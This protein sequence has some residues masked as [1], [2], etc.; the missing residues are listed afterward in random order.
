MYVIHINIES[1]SGLSFFN[2]NWLMPYYGF[3]HS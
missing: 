2:N 1:L 3:V